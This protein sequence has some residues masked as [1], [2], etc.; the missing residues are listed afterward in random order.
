MPIEHKSNLILRVYEIK[1]LHGTLRLRKIVTWLN[2]VFIVVASRSKACTVLWLL[3]A[4][5]LGANPNRISCIFGFCLLV[6]P[7]I[8]RC[9]ATVCS[10]IQG[11]TCQLLSRWFLARLILRPWRWRPYV[12]PKRRWAFNG[13]HGIVSQRISIL[14]EVTSNVCKIPKPRE[15]GVFEPHR[16]VLW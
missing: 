2:R 8:S 11:V 16:S 1:C 9:L 5:I 10:P 15:T 13:R 3:N 14:Q 12:R 6:L 4:E 7:S